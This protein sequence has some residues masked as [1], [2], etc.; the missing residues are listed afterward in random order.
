MMMNPTVGPGVGTAGDCRSA[1]ASPFSSPSRIPGLPDDLRQFWAFVSKVKREPPVV[2]T[3]APA[4]AD[5]AGPAARELFP[6]PSAP[7]AA[8]KPHPAG[9]PANAALPPRTP[10]SRMRKMSMLT[11]PSERSLAAKDEASASASAIS[12]MLA[13]KRSLPSPGDAMTRTGVVFDRTPRQC[14]LMLTEGSTCGSW[15]GVPRTPALS[16]YG[17]RRSSI[18]ADEDTDSESENVDVTSVV[19]MGSE[20]RLFGPRHEPPGGCR[21]LNARTG[22]PFFT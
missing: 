19:D 20:V 9:N 13:R 7:L 22:P 10:A 14:G 21:W 11:P 12:P 1:A 2:P 3:L 15:C 6:A 17:D 8:T 16:L 5:A 18:P 4:A